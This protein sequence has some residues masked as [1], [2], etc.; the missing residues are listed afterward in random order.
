MSDL[1]KLLGD[2]QY[3]KIN[4]PT[5]IDHGLQPNTVISRYCTIDEFKT[6]CETRFVYLYEMNATELKDIYLFRYRDLT[7]RPT[8]NIVQGVIFEPMT[9]SSNLVPLANFRISLNLDVMKSVLDHFG[10]DE[11][12]LQIGSKIIAARPQTNFVPEAS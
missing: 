11:V 10:Q 7:K 2:V 3:H 4:S 1:F 12:A 9:L 5:F 8:T 6:L